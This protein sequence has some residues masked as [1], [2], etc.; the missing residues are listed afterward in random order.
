M[1]AS[2]S[3][4]G[5][6]IDPLE[7]GL[8]ALTASTAPMPGGNALWRRA[9][10]EAEL[11]NASR[12]RHPRAAPPIFLHRLWGYMA[13][14]AALVLV[15]G[16]ML[17]S[18][19]KA[20]S[21]GRGMM[22]RFDGDALSAAEPTRASPSALSVSQPASVPLLER[23]VVQRGTVEIRVSDV[24]AAFS[25]LPGLLAPAGGEFIEQS[26]LSGAGANAVG[27]ATL[28]V[29]TKRL[30]MVQA[31][32]AEWGTVIAQ[33]S[34]GEDVTDQAID[35]EARLAVERRVERELLD[36][37]DTRNGSPLKEILEVREQLN[38]VRTQIERLVAQQ[39]RLDGLVA[40]ATLTVTLRGP[41]PETV[42][43]TPNLFSYAKQALS[44]AW[45]RS[46]TSA[47]DSLA[48]L[49]SVA[50]GGLFVWI[51]LGAIVIILLR[52]WR[53]MEARSAHE[54]P[55]RLDSAGD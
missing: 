37:L 4:A 8:V 52:V 42:V 2:K 7:A 47:V 51:G 54:P 15:V 28:R 30:G 43:N 32:L 34:A 11:L 23:R 50:V 27:S 3:I 44:E 55:P 31:A 10:Q 46:L 12:G 36:L 5:P 40:L 19:G 16:L 48:W 1:S 9:A 17:P 38:A 33:T 13:A 35:L 39:N 53:S 29:S 6:V 24:P 41:A 26:S 21:A 14:A 22:A 49:V 18:L 20:R 45:T 25:R